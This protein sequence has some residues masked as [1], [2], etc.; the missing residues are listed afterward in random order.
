MKRFSHVVRR[1]DQKTLKE[2]CKKQLKNG[3][4][5][6]VKSYMEEQNCTR[7]TKGESYRGRYKEQEQLQKTR[8]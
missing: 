1:E 8:K 3:E 2:T 7:I 4:R 6:D 5:E